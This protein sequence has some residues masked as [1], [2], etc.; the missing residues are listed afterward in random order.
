VRGV[1]FRL[2][3]MERRGCSWSLGQLMVFVKGDVYQLLQN[4]NYGI[5]IAC[6]LSLFGRVAASGLS[7]Y[8]VLL[9]FEI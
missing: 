4:L 3:S 7:I 9:V 1:H 8:F 6:L 2:N 5:G